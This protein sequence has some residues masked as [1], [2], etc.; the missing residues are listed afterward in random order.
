[1]KLI[2]ETI[3]QMTKDKLTFDAPHSLENTFMSIFNNRS[4]SLTDELAADG[5]SAME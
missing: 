2:T 5:F 1:M 4:L 3:E